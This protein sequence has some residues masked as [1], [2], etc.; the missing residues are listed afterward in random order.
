MAYRTDIEIAVKGAR[1]LKELQDQ[2]KVTG[3]KISV[4]NDN[5]NASGKL[6]S[7]SFNSVKT[8][9][10]EA[11]KNFDE[12]ALGTS[13][14]VTAAREYYQASKDL[15][16]ALRERVK[17]LDDIE[18][19]ERGV[20]LANIRASQAAREASGFG[21]FSADI[22]VPT[23]K[24]IRRNKEKI[25]RIQAKA[26][27]DMPAMQAPLMLPSSE[28]LNASQRG[29]KQLSSYYGDVNTQ[30]D[31]GVQS[32]RAF[33]EQL[34][35][36]ASKAQTLPPI[37]TQ[38]E[39][40]V[41]KTANALKPSAKIQQSWA[42]ALQQGA[43]WSKQGALASKEDL[44]LA[45]KQVL[46]ER[47]ITFE[48]RLQARLDKNAATSRKNNAALRK[49]IGGRLGSAAIGGA[50][51]LLFG[52][53]G[54]AAAGGAIGGLLG[55]A[56]GGFAGSLVGTLI[57][58]LISVRQEIEELGKEMGLGADGA[59][60]LGQAFR[61][62]GADAD[63]FQAAVQNIRGVGFAS[64]DELNV[65]RL[66]SKLTED[67][68][69]KVDKVSQ[70]YASIATSGKAGLS[71]VFKFT[72][73]GIPVLQQLEKNLGLNRSQLLQFIKDGKLT[74]QELSDALVQIANTSRE[75]AAKTYT[76][77]DKAWKDIGATTSRVL[78]AI[79][80]LLKPL[81]DDVARVA[82]R[83]AEIFAELYRYLVDG[84]I[85][86]AQ[87]IANA[88]AGIANDFAGLLRSVGSSPITGILLGKGAEEGF[89]QDAKRATELAEKLRKG[90]NDL[91][92]ALQPAAPPK[93][94]GIT[95]PGLQ[96][97]DKTKTGGGKSRESRIPVLQEELRLA[98]QLAGIRDKIRAAEF[99]ED[100][101]TQ[102]RLQNEYRR[103][104]IASEINK[105]KLSDV[106]VAEKVLQIS[107][108]ELQARESQRD[109]TQNLAQLERDRVRDFNKTVEGLELE[110][111][112][113]QAVTREEENRL[114][115]VQ[116][117][118]SL[119]GKNLNEDEVNRIIDL[120]TKIQEAQAPIQS[121]ITQTQKWLNDTQGMIVSLAQS[122]ETSISGAMA[123]AVEALVTGAKTV[124]DVLSEMFA[125]IG[126]AFL[127]MAAE[128]IAKQLVM[129]T[130][131]T[132]LKALGAVSGGGGGSSMDLSG[133]ETFNVPVSQMPAGMQF[134]EGGYVTKP[135]NA[136]IGEGGEPEYV[137]PAS[138]MSGAMSRYS[139]GKRGSS[140]INGAATTGG[141]SAAGGG[142]QVIRFE[143]TVINNVE[144][145]TRSQAEAMSRQAAK[146]GAAGGY[147]K[148][149]GGLRNSRATRA[150][151]G[152]G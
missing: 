118:L 103:A 30:I 15:N 34:N 145:V 138:K 93:I 8:V 23:Q 148:T 139:S 111:D 21:A 128:I 133:T 24:A 75:E 74:A 80:T 62:A 152:M 89:L 106:P 11:A 125:Q 25:E 119:E 144:Y 135:T 149:M 77:W 5:L 142:S 116:K 26:F 6:L 60:L 47:A 76:P 98:Q 129:I 130:L 46:A 107:K 57:G 123:G 121:Y 39:T 94:E 36:Q 19:A 61:Q 110:L 12:A 59:K 131:Q 58:D 87:G 44:A 48:K 95:L 22:D 97:T 146:Q 68:G 65:I 43:M 66:A 96:D 151:V 143:S 114:K 1:Q 122:V 13:K 69:G 102:I 112:I 17:L 70:A 9:V 100:K 104:E 120:V 113:A 88:L 31:L 14:A 150:R 54:L 81:V 71:D 141:G 49:D 105:V 51:P 16:N 2:I 134:A 27:R 56:G 136:L 117:R 33:T 92:A 67:Y 84:A 108:L 73:Q 91:R 78:N 41:T 82:T 140:V 63:K 124:Q 85:K 28:M 79:K 132:I 127:N 55:G 86:A 137:I 4:L 35:A 3:I 7:K 115:I 37:F 18:R 83:I 10:A 32:G 42:E 72:A 64:E 126:R 52:Q 101:A 50:F 29:I 40:A 20:V 147:A 109:T 45:D 38:F 53:S 99:D 90:A